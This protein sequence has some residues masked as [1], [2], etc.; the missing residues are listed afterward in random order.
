MGAE[1]HLATFSFPGLCQTLVKTSTW[2]HCP[3]VLAG[4][5]RKVAKPTCFALVC[6]G[7]SGLED[8]YGISNLPSLSKGGSFF[9]YSWSYFAYK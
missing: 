1:V 9:T 6:S 3:Q 4:T 7:S 8:S 5:A 2:G